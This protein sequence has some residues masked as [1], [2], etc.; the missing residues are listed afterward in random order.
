MKPI[1]DKNQPKKQKKFKKEYVFAVLICVAVLI[2]FIGNSF[3][4]DKLFSQTKSVSDDYATILEN[5]LIDILSDVEDVGKVNVFVTTAGSDSEVV[6]K[7]TEEKVENG[8]KTHT[9]TVVLVGG[10]PYVLSTENPKII[11]VIVVCEGAEKL[12]V[13]MKITEILTT[14]LKLDASCVQIIKMK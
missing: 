12:N 8:N 1:E 9:E 4:G 11:G 14:S 5:K 13:K 6:L 10:K 2:L 7:E 3:G